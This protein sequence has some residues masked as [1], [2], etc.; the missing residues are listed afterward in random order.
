[1]SIKEEKAKLSF[2]RD[3]GASTVAFATGTTKQAGFP[4]V[5]MVSEVNPLP[6]QIATG[7]TQSAMFFITGGTQPQPADDAGYVKT[8]NPL[9]VA[10]IGNISSTG[11]PLYIVTGAPGVQ[12]LSNSGYITPDYPLPVSRDG[13]DGPNM[14]YSVPTGNPDFNVTVS[15]GTRTIRMTNVGYIPDAGCIALPDNVKVMI[16]GSTE[17]IRQIPTNPIR[18]TSGNSGVFNVTFS[19]MTFTFNATDV[20][21]MKMIGPTKNRDSSLNAEQVTDISPIQKLRNVQ[22]NLVTGVTIG[23]LDNTWKDQGAEIPMAERNTLGIWVKF[24]ANNTTSG[25]MVQVLSKH[26]SG[27]VDEYDMA[28]SGSFQSQI[29]IANRKYWIPFN[30][31]NLVDYVQIQT[32]GTVLG[33]TT[34][35][36][37]IDITKAYDA[38]GG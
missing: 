21:A 28:S 14:Y 24:T 37:T 13:G 2:A 26:T 11:N 35:T 7:D 36:V 12:P 3:E 20:I 22:T 4:G 33:A 5:V 19:G 1:M 29:G 23:N 10:T 31:V 16:C 15:A 6:V 25:A 17:V 34:G 30:T 32:K 18:V 9:P 8:S 38:G 27:G